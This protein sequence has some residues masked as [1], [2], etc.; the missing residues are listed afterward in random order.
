MKNLFLIGTLLLGAMFVSCGNDEEEDN[1]TPSASKLESSYLKVDGNF[2]YSDTNLPSSTT[3]DVTLGNVT[4]NTTAT[5]GGM[6]RI[7]FQVQQRLKQIHI[8]IQG[9]PG[10]I[11]MNADEYLS[12]SSSTESRSARSETTTYTYWISVLYSNDLPHEDFNFLICGETL[13][14]AITPTVTQS[15]SYV[16]TLSGDLKV[17]LTFY[18]EKD[19]DLHLYTPLYNATTHYGH[20]YYGNRFGGLID[21]NY[22]EGEYDNDSE[23][24]ETGETFQLGLDIDSNAGCNIDHIKIENIF[25]PAAYLAAGEYS[26]VVD[27]Y[28]NCTPWTTPTAWS[29]VAYYQ[30]NLITPTEGT[31]PAYG[32]YPI[33]AGSYDMTK[34]MKFVITEAQAAKARGGAPLLTPKAYRPTRIDYAKKWNAEI[35][36]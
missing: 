22:D 35:S 32:E 36:D 9:I 16:K 6:N 17:T 8:G 20:I 31:N 4:M 13:D 27:M 1:P 28:S 29:C 25:I 5:N 14:G 7:N 18:A 12:P 3:S 30:G 10:H 26:V 19:V 2:T 33:D 23:H 34:V 21:T 15:V 11:T 24:E